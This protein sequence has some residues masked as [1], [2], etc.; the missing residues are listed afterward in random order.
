M[1]VQLDNY[2]E[3]IFTQEY[4]PES[5]LQGV[6]EGSI[7]AIMSQVRGFYAMRTDYATLLIPIDHIQADDIVRALEHRKKSI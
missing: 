3:K 1:I 5:L 6:E 4:Y 2:P 7:K